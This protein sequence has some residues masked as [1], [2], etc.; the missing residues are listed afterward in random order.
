MGCEKFNH[1]RPTVRAFGVHKGNIKVE[2]MR[3]GCILPRKILRI[4]KG[5]RKKAIPIDA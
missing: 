1:T 3:E 2:F 5:L 4:T